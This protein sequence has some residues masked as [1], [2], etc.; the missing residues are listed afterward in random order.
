MSTKELTLLDIDVRLED[1]RRSGSSEGAK[2]LFAAAQARRERG[3]A[4][5]GREIRR[6]RVGTNQVA[7]V[8]GMEKMVGRPAAWCLWNRPPSDENIAFFNRE[9]SG[10][11]LLELAGTPEFLRLPTDSDAALRNFERTLC[12]PE[13]MRERDAQRAARP[14]PKYIEPEHRI[15]LTE[16]ASLGVARVDG[17]SAAWILWGKDGTQEDVRAARKEFLGSPTLGAALLKYGFGR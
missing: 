3:G 14:V 6:F 9:I 11:I 1:L 7:L 8:V 5:A 10:R 4:D 15:K 2:E 13:R 16:K 12:T 17:V